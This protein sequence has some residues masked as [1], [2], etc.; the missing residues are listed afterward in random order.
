MCIGWREG[1]AWRHSV[2][3][4][5]P[6]FYLGRMLERRIAQIVVTECILCVSE[7]IPGLL[8]E[9]KL[10][11]LNPKKCNKEIPTIV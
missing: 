7:K 6:S 8:D 2:G 5:S 1:W 3:S 11:N 4:V 10:T 9:V